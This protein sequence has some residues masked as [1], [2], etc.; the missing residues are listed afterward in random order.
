M[1]RNSG[2][3]L[4]ELVIV[5]IVLGILSATAVPKFINLQDDAKNAVLH[6]ISGAVNSA[7]DI[8]YTKLAINGLEHKASVNVI[9]TPS[10]AEWCQGCS[11]SYGYPDGLDSWSSIIEGINRADQQADVINGKGLVFGSGG[12]GIVFTMQGNYIGNSLK[13]DNCYVEYIKSDSSTERPIVN[14]VECK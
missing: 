10:L 13:S 5:I 12:S 3:T 6:G 8:S 1:K 4:I 7:M 9:N 14:V 11:F 2:F